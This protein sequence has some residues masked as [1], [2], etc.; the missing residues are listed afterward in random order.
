LTL[1]RVKM[2]SLLSK[3]SS[4]KQSQTSYHTHPRAAYAM[5]EFDSQAMKQHVLF[6]SRDIPMGKE[7]DEYVFS[8]DS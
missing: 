3:V 6:Y 7:K 8:Q 4:K 1:L 5:V 2:S